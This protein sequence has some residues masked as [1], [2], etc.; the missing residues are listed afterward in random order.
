[1]GVENVCGYI[2]LGKNFFFYI[3][4]WYIEVYVY[5]L[6]RIDIR[7][8]QILLIQIKLVLKM[9]TIVIYSN[10]FHFNNDIFYENHIN[11]I[12]VIQN[13]QLLCIDNVINLNFFF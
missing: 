7:F 2:V 12:Y 4:Y 13:F 9:V 6:S 11:E 10:D 1:M 8:Y 5:Y 3:I